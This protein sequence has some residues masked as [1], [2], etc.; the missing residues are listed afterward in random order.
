[1]V[2]PQH[3]D[4]VLG[5]LEPVEF[6]EHTAKL[7]VHVTTSGVVAVDQLSGGG[8]IGQPAGGDRIVVGN[9]AAALAG[10]RRGAARGVEVVQDGEFRG[11]V[12][13][14]VFFRRGEGQV[15]LHEAQREE[16]GCA[17]P[18]FRGLQA[19][20]PVVGDAPVGVGAVGDVAAF[21]SGTFRELA[22]AV[23]LLVGEVGLLA[24]QLAA[25][26]AFRVE[27]FDDLLDVGRHAPRSGV[28]GVA[29]AAVEDLADG[30]RAVA[31]PDEMLA[32]RHRI[33]HRRAEIRGEAVDADR[34]RARPQHQA[35]ARG[36]ADRLVAV[37]AF[38]AETAGGEAVEVW[39][40]GQRVPVAAERRLEVI[41]A[42]Q[43]DIG[44]FRRRC[45]RDEKQQ[46]GKQGFHER[47][48]VPS[49]RK[50]SRPERMR[51][52]CA[53]P[54]RMRPRC[55]GRSPARPSHRHSRHRE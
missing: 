38:E 11:I 8:V 15:R 19:L 32:Q 9:L 29:V 42:D 2:A 26:G 31:V 52:A 17:A 27:V 45:E 1:M 16:E 48:S 47:V 39:S 37:G 14:P 49:A 20:D 51:A 30:F 53:R 33:R 54:S 41:D 10:A 24:G 36:G 21:P 50:S 4:G 3:D 43:Q 23:E 7:R 22:D 13:V 6:I 40:L 35:V 44:L 28:I 55:R 46:G 25:A 18:L 5:K 34:G 12:E